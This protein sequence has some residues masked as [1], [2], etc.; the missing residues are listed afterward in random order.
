VALEQLAEG[1]RAAV[2]ALALSV[3]L[4]L[5]AVLAAWAALA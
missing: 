5:R 3:A 4:R 1:L 2:V